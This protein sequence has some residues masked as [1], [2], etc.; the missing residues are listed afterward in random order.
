MSKKKRR[1]TCP[2]C[3][4]EIAHAEARMAEMPPD[5]E[6]RTRI[7]KRIGRTYYHFGGLMCDEVLSEVTDVVRRNEAPIQ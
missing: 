1:P 6:T 2:E 5:F 3:G 7:W 4:E